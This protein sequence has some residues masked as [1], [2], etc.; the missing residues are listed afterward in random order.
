M[1]KSAL[2]DELST[3]APQ[4]P[5]QLLQVSPLSQIALPQ[6]PVTV[7]VATLLS[8]IALV[9][10]LR[11]SWIYVWVPMPGMPTLVVPEVFSV[12]AHVAPLLVSLRTHDPTFAFCENQYKL[13]DVPVGTLKLLL[14]TWL[15]PTSVNV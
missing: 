1:V 6:E 12:V 5:G 14:Y 8:T 10:L 9:S 7:S 3:Q 2:H 4:S 13:T 11:H 15:K